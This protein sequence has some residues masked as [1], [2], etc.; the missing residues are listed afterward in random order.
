VSGRATDVE[1]DVDHFW[2]N[3]EFVGDCW[4]WQGPFFKKGYGSFTGRSLSAH[5]VAFYLVHGYWPVVCRHSC[6][7]RRCI[8]PRHLLDGTHAD[9]M[10]DAVERGR[11]HNQQKTTCPDEHPLSGENLYL[12]TRGHRHCLTCK[13]QQ[14]RECARRRRARARSNA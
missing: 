1:I 4:E 7:N 2:S 3:L 5:R 10:R 8:N 14:A 12:D 13:R 6:D 9:N 11:L